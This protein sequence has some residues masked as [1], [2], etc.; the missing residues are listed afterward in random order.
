MK[1]LLIGG[2][3]YIGSEIYKYLKSFDYDVSSVDACWH[4]KNLGYNFEI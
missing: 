1:I 4:N 2:N 3:G